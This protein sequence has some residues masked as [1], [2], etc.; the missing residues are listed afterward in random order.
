[1]VPSLNRPGGNVTGATLISAALV[2]K[3]IELLHELIPGAE[4][5][6]VLANSNN[7]SADFESRK[8]KTPRGRLD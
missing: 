1:L 5:I 4:L 3:R 6:A 2:A 7:P 8:R